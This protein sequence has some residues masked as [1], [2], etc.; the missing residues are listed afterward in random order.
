MYSIEATPSSKSG[1]VTDSGGE[2]HIPPSTRADGSK[3]KEIKIRPGYKPPEDVEVYKNRT[4]ESWKSR[5]YNGVPGFDSNA[6]L[7]LSGKAKS[8][9]AKRREARQKASKTA[10]EDPIVL[11]SGDGGDDQNQALTNQRLDILAESD[12]EKLILPEVLKGGQEGEQERQARKLG[13]KLRQAK[14]LKQ[15]MEDGE[16]LLPE[17]LEKIIRISELNRELEKLGLDSDGN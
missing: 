12:L 3:R 6:K 8:K 10:S 7:D 5:S 13:K 15:K 4:A 14:E 1:I 2:R 16:S 11:D 17:Q 9:S